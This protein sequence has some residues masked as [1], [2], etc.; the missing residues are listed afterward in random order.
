MIFNCFLERKAN[1][2]LSQAK[3]LE[4]QFNDAQAQLRDI[5]SLLCC[6]VCLLILSVAVPLCPKPAIEYF[7]TSIAVRVLLWLRVL[8]GPKVN[9]RNNDL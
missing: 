6:V 3:F 8:I 7:H 1:T 4:K 5:V 9:L 2:P